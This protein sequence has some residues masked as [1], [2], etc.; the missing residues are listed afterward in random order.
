MNQNAV[1]VLA[2]PL[3]L[4]CL[5]GLFLADYHFNASAGQTWPALLIAA[6]LLRLLGWGR[7]QGA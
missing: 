5:G 1:E 6:G 3:L 4:I 7:S 2:V